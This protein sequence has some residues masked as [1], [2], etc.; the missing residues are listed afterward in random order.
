MITSQEALHRMQDADPVP[1]LDV[2]PDELVQSAWGIIG[3]QLDTPV[4]AAPPTRFDRVG[5][6]TVWWRRPA[7]VVALAFALTVIVGGFAALMRSE[8]APA[9][10][11]AT[12]TPPPTTLPLPASTTIEPITTLPAA[13]IPEK[14]ASL[15]ISWHRVS[16][17]PSLQ[18]GWISAV[19][20]GGSGYVAVGGTV[21][22]SN[23]SSANCR[24]DA[25]VWVSAD[26]LVW[27][28]VESDS[29]RSD[30]VREVSHGDPIDGDQFMNDVTAG[31]AGLVA[32][33]AA[34][35]ID[36]DRASGYL[37][38][39]GI[40]LSP[41]GLGWDL[42]PYNEETFG[43]VSEIRR[44]VTLDDRLVAVGGARAWVSTDGAA[45]DGTVIDPSPSAKVF[46]LTVWNGLAVAVGVV[47][48]H[49]AVWASE[50]GAVWTSVAAPDLEAARGS[51][52]GI[53][54]SDSGL[55]ALGT[56]LSTARTIAWRSEDGIEWTALPDP[57]GDGQEWSDL[58]RTAVSVDS[59]TGGIGDDLVLM[60]GSATL[61]GTADGGEFWYPAGEF[62]GGVVNELGSSASG[63][64][65]IVNQV[66]VADG[67]LLAVGKVVAWS[68][69]EPIGGPCYIDS[70]G[71]CRA[72]AAIWV[73]TWAGSP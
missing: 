31:P 15:D 13:T 54:G 50:D 53:G 61:W 44:I 68:S 4:T 43:G 42:L 5:A 25:A 71:S 6:R 72:D 33:G 36:P 10:D 73:G 66:M 24:L 8:Q 58:A 20:V 11:V 60:N 40:W 9:G 69:T 62:D 19:T 41:D 7:L 45:W 34:P 16:E 2:V 26:G 38:R 57:V 22:C 35:V 30:A 37:E 28:R 47:D 64:F 63:G 70:G 21:G 67:R 49:P 12:S 39:V 48:D 56:N 59:G 51:L 29:F 18:D 55:V 46:D 1:N 32:V 17:Q 27:E 14:P 3:I 52:Q 23:P 65:N